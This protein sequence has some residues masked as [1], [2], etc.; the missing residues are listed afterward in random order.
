MA[1]AE[2][3]ALTAADLAG[4]AAL[5]D[6]SGLCGEGLG[7][8][9][10]IFSARWAGPD[11]DFRLAM[12]LVEDNLGRI[13][14]DAGRDAHFIC[15]LS[16]CWPDGHVANFEGRVDGTLVRPPAGHHGLGD[17]P[18]FKTRTAGRTHGEKC[19]RTG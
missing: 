15:A 14:P 9:P 18:C 4:L 10:G 7:G 16:P 17:G 5:A 19:G 2:L 13:G 8:E 3:K 11:K 1:N 12:Q 6:D